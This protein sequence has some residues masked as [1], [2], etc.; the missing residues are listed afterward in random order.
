MEAPRLSEDVEL[1]PPRGLLS[2]PVMRP[3]IPLDEPEPEPE[4]ELEL[5]LDFS[6]CQPFLAMFLKDSDIAGRSAPIGVLQWYKY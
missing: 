4:P 5:E 6:G 3:R 2:R 1:E